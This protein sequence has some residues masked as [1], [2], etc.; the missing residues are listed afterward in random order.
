MGCG[1][2]SVSMVSIKNVKSYQEYRILRSL[3]LQSLC[4]LYQLSGMPALE[5][6]PAEAY[7]LLD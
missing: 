4:C 2:L 5:P 1:A 7:V 3:F 6:K